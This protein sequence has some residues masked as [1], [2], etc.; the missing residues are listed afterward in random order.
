M[1]ELFIYTLFGLASGFC[2]GTT[3]FNPVS[4]IL[5]LLDALNIGDYRSNLGSIMV[6][7]LFP[8]TSGSVYR[9][10]KSNMINWS[11]A[12]I[13]IVTITLGSYYGSAL[14][15]NK[16]YELTEKSIKYFS[17]CLSL[18]I[19]FSFLISAYYEKN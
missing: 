14:I 8:I 9:F 16:K 11:L 15:T 17:A 12:L 2:L 18:L 1:L 19:G 10:Y 7:N 6:L 4:L 5:L 13:L 3:G